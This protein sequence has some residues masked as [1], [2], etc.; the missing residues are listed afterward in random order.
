[1]CAKLGAMCPPMYRRCLLAGFALVLALA[2][3]GLPALR[4]ASPP[5]F[6][7]IIVFGDSLSDTGN[8]ANVSK[9]DY[10]VT[11][12]GEDFNYT[13]GR[14]TNGDDTNPPST[15]YKGVWHEQLAR[16]FLGIPSATNS[17]NGGMDYAYGGA[18]TNNGTMSLSPNSTIA[19]DLDVSITIDNMGAQITDYLNHNST[20][21]NALYI[22]WGGANDLFDNGTSENAVAAADRETALIKRLAEAGAV[23]FLVP[24]LPPLGATPNYNTS[25]HDSAEINQSTID[26][27]TELNSDLNTL[28][29]N[30]AAAGRKVKIYRLDVFDL[31][32][33]LLMNQY[34]YGF[35]NITDS[36]QGMSVKADTYLFWDDVHP[37]VAGHYQL[38]AEA[39]SVLTGTPVVEINVAP[40][41]TLNSRGALSIFYLTRTGEDLTTTLKVPYTT[42]GT[43]KPETNYVELPGERN[44]KAGKQTVTIA[45][46]EGTVPPVKPAKTISLKIVAGDGYVLPA[47]P[48]ATVKLLPQPTPSGD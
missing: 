47:V 36:A 15:V 39:Y 20:D 16:L 10:D 23:T 46:D 34:A 1:M 2:F 41:G 22:V 45:V 8:D 19:K 27:C 14:F 25:P 13:T 3:V 37:T 38:A 12:P 26:F 33:R 48:T 24:N 6:S 18:T 44:L 21:A 42:G 17:L 5:L 40:G 7:Q 4:A 9:G 32:G 30:L 31:F 11:F 28:E 43:A 29:T 35:L